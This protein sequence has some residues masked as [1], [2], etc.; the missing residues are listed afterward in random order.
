MALPLPDMTSK[1]IPR[2]EVI[3]T[4]EEESFEHIHKY[5]FDKLPLLKSHLCP[6][7]IIYD[8]G[9]KLNK[10]PD[11]LFIEVTNK[12]PSLL[13]IQALYTAW[14]QWPEGAMEDP[15]YND[16][17]NDYFNEDDTDDR[18]KSGRGYPK[19]RR[20]TVVKSSVK[21]K[22]PKGIF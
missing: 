19:K 7:F 18:T 6:N 12:Y 20:A 10:L 4:D 21:L 16:D 17:H 1:S 22:R 3:P 13:S 8:V 5:P 2:L 14:R 9:Y 15:S 11:E